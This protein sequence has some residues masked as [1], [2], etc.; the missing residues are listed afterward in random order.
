MIWMEDKRDV[1][2][3]LNKILISFVETEKHDVNLFSCTL[4]NFRAGF[5][6]PQSVS[7]SV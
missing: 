3:I 5:E 1:T 4:L 6:A 2:F 7:C